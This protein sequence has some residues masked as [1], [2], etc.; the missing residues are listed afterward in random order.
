MMAYQWAALAFLSAFS[1]A[2]SDA[3][4]KR[5]L[6]RDNEYLVTWFRFVFTLPVFLVLWVFVPKPEL[7]EQFFKAF[8]YALPLEVIATALYIKALRLSPLNMTL[9]FTALTPVFLIITSY[10]IAGERI[11]VWGGTGVFFLALGSYTLNIHE[12]KNGIL[13]P[14]KSV[15][16]EKGSVLMII[17][18]LIYSITASLGKVGVVNSSPLFFGITYYI[19]LSI[20]YTPFA[21]WMG[22]GEIKAF[23]IEKRFVQMILPGF[24]NAVMVASHM[25]AINLAQVAY[26]VSVKRTS[27]LISVI[28]GYYFFREGNIR[29]RLSGTVLMIIGFTI[30]VMSV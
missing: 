13:E 9:P 19:A 12:M 8:I 6:A 26:V 23:I 20:V 25:L 22:R 2:T 1:L 7:N 16:R 3:L 29:E 18:A 24:L 28:Y 5:A 14:L 30:I 27:I 15:A 4:T 10:F 17:V 21:L 11:S